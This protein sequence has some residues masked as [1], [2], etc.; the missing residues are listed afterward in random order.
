MRIMR[1]VTSA[2]KD[3]SAAVEETGRSVSNSAAIALIAVLLAAVAVLSV[4][5]IVAARTQ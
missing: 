2:A 4:A 5:V 3:A 1:T